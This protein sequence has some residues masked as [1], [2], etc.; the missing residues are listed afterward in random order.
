MVA[1]STRRGTL[2]R[3]SGCEVSSA[4]HMIGRAEFLA[5]EMRTSPSSARPPRMR[6]LSTRT[7]FLRRERAHG[8][9]VDFLAHALAERRVDELM[10]LHAAAPG[11][12]G[13][14]D[15]R[16]EMLP[17]ADHLHVLAREPRPAALLDALRLHHDQ[18]LNLAPDLS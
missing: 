8:K 16:L 7:P 9:G 5:P 2:A 13:G 4:A 17:V 6:S 3:R 11:G 18:V 15:Q 12:L 1:T 14:H 10:A